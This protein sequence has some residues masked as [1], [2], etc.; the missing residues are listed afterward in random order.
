ME[1]SR[2]HYVEHVSMSQLHSILS[3]LTSHHSISIGKSLCN[4]LL[5][6][7]HAEVILQI[8]MAILI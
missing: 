2:I 8:R 6:T 3:F 4:L 5:M 7:W 1:R